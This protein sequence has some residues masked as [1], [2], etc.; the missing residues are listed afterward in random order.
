MR[1]GFFVLMVEWMRQIGAN[2]VYKKPLQKNILAQKRT[3]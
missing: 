1:G 3:K 2:D